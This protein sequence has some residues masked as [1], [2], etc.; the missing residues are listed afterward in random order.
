MESVLLVTVD[1]LRADHVGYHGYERETTPYLDELVERASTFSN[2]YVPVGGTRYAFPSILSSVTPLDHGGHDRVAGSQTLVSEVFAE[3]GYR[4]GGFHSNLF[5]SA[6]RGYDRGFD[7]F[8]DSKDDPSLTTRLRS[9]ARTN[10]QGTPVY[11]LLQRAYDRVESSGGVNVG[12]FH[13][14]GDELTDRALAWLDAAADDPPFFLWV[15]YM[16]VHHPY[17]PPATDQRRFRDAVVGD[18]EAVTLRRK[19]VDRPGDLTKAELATLVDLYDA[20]IRFTDRQVERLVETARDRLD[21]LTVAVTADHGEHFLEHGSFSGARASDVKCHVPLLVDGWDDAGDYD[22]LVG[23]CDLPPT[24]LD[25][26]G[27]ESPASYRGES[28]AGLVG[29]GDWERESVVGGWADDDGRTY[30]YRDDRWTFV[31]RPGDS[32]DELYDRDADPGEQHDVA[33]DHPDRVTAFAA[34]LD[35][36]RAEIRATETDLD[37]VATDAETVERL[38]RLGYRE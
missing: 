12:S 30:V 19:A 23:L 18:R 9:F 28:L 35:E 21:D 29:D 25:A 34:R 16:D 14:R 26:A 32:P 15:H 7:A 5:L 27:L 31:E 2:A 24:L 4:T 33:G 37:G 13:V 38:R 8:F 11:P 22:A 6:E 10:L 20:E 36:H 17:L 3:A 1:S